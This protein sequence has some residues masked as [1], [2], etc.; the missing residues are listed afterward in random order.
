MKKLAMM[1]RATERPPISLGVSQKRMKQ[2][3][4]LARPMRQVLWALLPKNL[5]VA[6][7]ARSVPTMPSTSVMPTTVEAVWMLRPLSWVRNVAPQSRMV[8]RMM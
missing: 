5:S 3:V 1:I 4:A 7:P 8:K 2:A 6:Q